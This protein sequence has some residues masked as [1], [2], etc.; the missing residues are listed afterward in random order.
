VIDLPFF[1][2]NHNV[3][4]LEAAVALSALAFHR[5]LAGITHFSVIRLELDQASM[6]VCEYE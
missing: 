4:A 2:Q 6:N 5:F 3:V 1:G